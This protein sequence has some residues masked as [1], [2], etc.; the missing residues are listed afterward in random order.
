VGDTG[1]ELTV[2][3]SSSVCSKVVAPTWGPIARSSGSW[4]AVSAVAAF[5]SSTPATIRLA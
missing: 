4:S 2:T 3:P 5:S 1:R